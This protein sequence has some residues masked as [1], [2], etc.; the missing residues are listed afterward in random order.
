MRFANEDRYDAEIRA[1]ANAYSVPV[2]LIK[3]IIGAESSFINGRASSSS[4]GLMQLYPPTAATFDASVT[5]SQLQNDAGI[6][7]DIGTRLLRR[8]IN[9][10]GEDFPRVASAYNAG[11]GNANIATT[12]YNFCMEWKGGKKPA[13]ANVE[14]DCVA[15]QIR[16][17]Q[18]GEYPNQSYVNA[19]M[20]NYEYF[21]SQ[22]APAPVYT[23]PAYGEFDPA[24]WRPGEQQ[25]A[26]AP[27]A[28]VATLAL[29]GLL[30]AVVYLRRR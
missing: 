4:Y 28:T 19:V 24:G 7:I 15:S 10:Y 12:P 2:A 14:R 25:G 30:A 11:E 13:N 18:P 1:A 3:A 22:E 29:V 16:R 5:L 26:S 21:S 20:S 27:A 23:G 17:V 9:R 8:L 6:N